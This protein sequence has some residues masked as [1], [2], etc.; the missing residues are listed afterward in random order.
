M[1][2]QEEGLSTPREDGF[3]MPAEWAPHGRCWMAWPCREELWGA[4]L[5]AARQAT[6]DIA[7][8]IAEF[9]PVTIIA[10]PELTASVSLYTGTGVAVLPMPHD[11]SWTRDTAPTF[12]VA[13]DGRLAGVDWQFNGWGE[14]YHDYAQD[15]QIAKR[16]L[17]QLN[18]QRYPAPIVFEGGAVHVDGEGTALLCEPS[19]LDPKRNPGRTREEIEAVL[20]DYLGVEKVIWLPFGLVDDETR[21]HVDNVASFAR[22]GLVLAHATDD[23]SDPNYE[24]TQAN[25]EILADATDAAGR[26]LEVVRLPQPRT[27]LRDDGRRL[28]LTYVNFYIANGAVIAPAFADPADA[29]AFKTLSSAFPDRQIIQI[30]ALDLV[31]GGGGIHCVTQQQPAIPVLDS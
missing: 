28:T 10:K 27:Q 18:L 19:V 7:N 11:D 16:L 17:E 21:G 20:G 3:R 23:A 5:D 1:T 15:A 25:L 8:A 22:P 31:H 29:T 6:A 14:V 30:E 24:G 4:R 26:P 2:D 12:V 9:E 13:G